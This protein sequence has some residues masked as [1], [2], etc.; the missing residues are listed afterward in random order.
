MAIGDDLVLGRAACQI[1]VYATRIGRQREVLLTAGD[2]NV[3]EKINLSDL[4][5]EGAPAL[6]FLQPAY[7]CSSSDVEIRSLFC[8]AIYI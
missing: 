7:L 5:R 4:A 8:N 6:L 1:L 3:V 2:G